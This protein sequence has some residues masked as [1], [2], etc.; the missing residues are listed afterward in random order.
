MIEQRLVVSRRSWLDRGKLNPDRVESLLV[1]GRTKK[2]C[3]EILRVHGHCGRLSA[4]HMRNY[5]S[6]WGT[7]IIRPEHEGRG[8]WL[9]RD[10]NSRE[11]IP[12]W[13]EPPPIVL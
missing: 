13:I 5:G 6:M 10:P 4:H 1:R 2:D 3:L 12:V 11:L 7:D 8:L 9:T